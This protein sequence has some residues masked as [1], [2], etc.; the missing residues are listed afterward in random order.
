MLIVVRRTETDLYEYLLR[1]FVGGQKR[2]HRAKR[3]SPQSPRLQ[4]AHAP[5]RRA[6][7]PAAN[8]GSTQLPLPGSSTDGGLGSLKPG[9]KNPPSDLLM[10]YLRLRPPVS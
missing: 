4:H 7:A 10:R 8:V 3:R 9:L 2:E 6:L 1:R 5:A